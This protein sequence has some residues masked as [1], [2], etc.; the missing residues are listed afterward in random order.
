MVCSAVPLSLLPPPP[1]AT[2]VGME[3]NPYDAPQVHGDRPPIA[4]NMQP[5][6][7]S[8]DDDGLQI[9]WPVAMLIN[10]TAVILV[11]AGMIRFAWWLLG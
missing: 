2:I 9:G 8:D 4:E 1:P 6:D 11:V 7:E 10:A 3:P 5:E